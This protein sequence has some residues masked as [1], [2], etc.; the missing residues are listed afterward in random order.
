MAETWRSVVPGLPVD[1]DGTGILDI[2][3]KKLG[4]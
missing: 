3:S 2:F 1:L 4:G